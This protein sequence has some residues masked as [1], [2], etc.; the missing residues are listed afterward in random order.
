MNIISYRKNFFILSGILV[1]ASIISLS[2]WRLNFGVDFTGGSLLEIEVEGEKLQ[3]RH[4]KDRLASLGLGDISAQPTGQSGFILRFGNIDEETHQKILRELQPITAGQQPATSSEPLI[5]ESM[6]SAGGSVEVQAIPQ[7]AED[8]QK[9]KGANRINEKRFESIGPNIGRE[10]KI[11]TFWA[12]IF[13]LLAIIVYIAW[14]FRKVSKPIA[15]WKYGLVAIV[16]LFH[17]VLITTGIFSILGKFYGVEIG[18]PFIAAIIT[19]L[20]YSVNDTIVVFDRIRENLKFH[21]GHEEFNEIVN[22]S[23]NQSVTRSINTSLTTLLVLM[24]LFLFGGTSL[25]DFILVLIFGIIFGTYS[26]IFIASPLL[27]E[28]EKRMSRRG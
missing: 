9:L 17:D 13:A 20:G 8:V 3:A 23:V 22:Q 12:I 10:L 26:S 7:R 28:W 25:R 27:V 21:Y 5:I 18:L 14:V 2:L 15:S 1:L 16:A 24:A 11:K 19:I 6:N 4:I